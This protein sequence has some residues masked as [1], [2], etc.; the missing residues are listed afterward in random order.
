MSV[1]LTK[2]ILRIPNSFLQLTPTE[3]HILTV[4]CF[5][6]LDDG[7]VYREIDR[8]ASDCNL[9]KKTI[10]RG[11]KA[12]RDKS[13]LTYT[14]KHIGTF[15]KIPIYKLDF[16]HGLSGGD[17][18]SITDSLS[19]RT[20]SL[21]FDHPHKVRPNKQYINNKI[22]NGKISSPSTSNPQT[23]TLTDLQNYAWH[24]KNNKNGIPDEL[25]W[26][27]DFI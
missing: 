3:K 8:L 24:S 25:K 1:D 17:L 6:S 26:V 9:S 19:K 2:D 10:E 4:L 16:V 11:L 21:S 15:N 5:I 13:Y 27:K 23:P 14:G 22:N 20:D 18:K 12:L 7:K